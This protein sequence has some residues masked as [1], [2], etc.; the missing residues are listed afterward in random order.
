MRLTIHD[1]FAECGQT[2]R[3]SRRSSLLRYI[4][5]ESRS[6]RLPTRW[7]L[8]TASPASSCS[9]LKRSLTENR[10]YLSSLPRIGQRTVG[11]E[12]DVT[13]NAPASCGEPLTDQR[14]RPYR[15]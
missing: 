8:A 13:A 11:R 3:T 10:R 1:F 9:S 6:E 4:S 2:P 15:G 14:P 12:A 7:P 5:A